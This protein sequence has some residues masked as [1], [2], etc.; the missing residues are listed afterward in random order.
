MTDLLTDLTNATEGSRDLS[1]RVLLALGWEKSSELYDI[2]LKPRPNSQFVHH[3]PNPTV[4][5]QDAVDLIPDGQLYTVGTFPR[6]GDPFASVGT[7]KLY[8]NANAPTDA[9][10]VCI[11]LLKWR[12]NS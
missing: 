6:G 8:C 2:W 12:R 7:G 9:L 11:A 4:N 1:D 10:A 5:L 3:S